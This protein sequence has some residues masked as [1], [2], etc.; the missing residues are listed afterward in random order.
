MPNSNQAVSL[1][2]TD[3]ADE[4]PVAP[5]TEVQRQAIDAL[6]AGD[7]PGAATLL[8]RALDEHPD[9]GEGLAHMGLCL[10]HQGRLHEARGYLVQAAR[11][12]PDDIDIY[13]N[14]GAVYQQ[15]GEHDSAL[16]C[17][18][19]VVLACPEDHGVYTQM[20][21]SA[22]RLGRVKD[23]A[24]LYAE[25]VRLRPDDLGSAA[26]LA[27]IH[28]RQG[29]LHHAGEVL[30]GALT[31]HPEDISLNLGM[32]L[33]LEM[34]DRYGEALPHFRNVLM[35]D[36]QHEE[37]YYHLGVCARASG[38]MQEA[39]AFLS[40]A[41]KLRPDYA[42]AWHELGELHHDRGD[43]ELATA[44]FEEALGQHRAIEERRKSWGET[45][46]PGPKART[47]NALARCC[48]ATGDGRRARA[49]WEES[50][51]LV[52]DQPEVVQA[53]QAATPRY[54]RASLTID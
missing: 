44:I 20:A 48:Q 15:L 21:E 50:L 43:L 49:L 41:V 33:V 26:A 52:P 37:G 38:L 4:A 47:L 17:Y 27:Q 12:M 9:W 42:E 1:S 51:S 6:N 2:Q 46:D 11:L 10:A 18:K 35:A 25:A 24:V 3:E 29:D 22:L 53:L 30:R 8:R 16:S 45:P 13:Y 32:G 7:W 28:L 39:E 14:L 54:R 36:D 19:E 31:H 23:A 34:Q 40:Q 5:A